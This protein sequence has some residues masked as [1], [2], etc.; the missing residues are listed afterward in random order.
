MIEM[1]AK[2]G[3]KIVEISLSESFDLCWGNTC[4][5]CSVTMQGTRYYI[6]VL[7]YGVCTNCATHWS[8]NSKFE[9]EDLHFETNA[10]RMLRSYGLPY[11]KSD[12]VL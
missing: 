5:M 3:F 10:I 12:H 1:N 7:N 6:P 2:S 11:T 8:N 9:A 4:D